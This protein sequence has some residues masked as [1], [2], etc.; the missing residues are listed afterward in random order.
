MNSTFQISEVFQS[1]WK[2]VKTQIWV[3]AGLLIGMCLISLVINLFTIPLQDSVFGMLIAYLISLIISAVF[4]IGYTKN[5]FQTMDGDEPQF[6]A[7]LQN[8]PKII[9]MLVANILM[10]IIVCVGLWIFVLPGIYLYLRLQFF[11]QF[12]V[13]E[14]AGIIDSL[15]RSWKVTKG[16]EMSLLLLALTEIFIFIIGAI[17]FGIGLFIA[18]PVNFMMNCYV[19][20]KLNRLKVPEE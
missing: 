4:C 9:N 2:Y 19:Y 1:S 7:Y 8:F 17:L 12:I 5:M 20:R 13:D 10:F 6:S 15:N 14:D 18:I 11:V 3:L 16:K